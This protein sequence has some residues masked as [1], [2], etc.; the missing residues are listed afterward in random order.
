MILIRTYYLL[1]FWQVDSKVVKEFDYET[2]CP[3]SV[4]VESKVM[5]EKQE[6][7]SA[8]LGI[9]YVGKYVAMFIHPL[10]VI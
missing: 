4:G 3:S 9:S 6:F 1:L 8:I 10:P 2:W 5:Y 7:C